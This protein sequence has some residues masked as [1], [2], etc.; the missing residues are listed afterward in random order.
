MPPVKRSDLPE[1]IR[2]RK[3]TTPPFYAYE[4]YFFAGPTLGQRFE[5]VGTDMRHAKRQLAERLREVAEGSYE[6]GKR[7]RGKITVSEFAEQWLAEREHDV[8]TIKLDRTRFRLH[9][10][11]A[12]G[13]LPVGAVETHHIVDLLAQLQRKM[14]ARYKRL[15]SKN[16]I[17]NVYANVN[18]MFSDAEQRGYALRNPCA[19]LRR[20][21]RPRKGRRADTQG[22]VLDADQ[23]SRLI[24]D[25]RIPIDRRTFYALEF[26]TGSRFGEAA[27]FRWR[28]YDAG[29]QPLGHL[30]L[31]HQYNGLP[32]KG[33]RGEPGPARDIPVHP[34]LAASLARWKTEGFRAMHGRDPTRDDFIVPSPV[35][36]CRSRRACAYWIKRDCATTGVEA[37][38]A[39]HVGRRTFI[40][41]AIA[42]GAPE[43]WVK[44][45]THNANGDVLSGY[46]VNDW[47]AMCDAVN[48][49]PVRTIAL[50]QV[51]E[52]DAT[53]KRV[54]SG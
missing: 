24:S 1:G 37:K 30:R 4:I 32:L 44:R 45:I 43:A 6:P 48:R 26:L 3:T 31:D 17:R 39:T 35:G 46:T 36:T 2:K 25:T 52:L 15:L 11:P 16:T 50:G 23:T 9:I 34:T 38:E 47:P 18:T 14:S 40:T 20:A 54:G 10:L 13:D 41:I 19:G 51:I 7:S 42:N 28:D 49:I 8:I 29:R 27:G 53:K 5:R 22:P 21:Q 33:R 12:I